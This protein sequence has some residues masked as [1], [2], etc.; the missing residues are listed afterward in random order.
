MNRYIFF[1]ASPGKSDM[2]FAKFL[3]C[4]LIKETEAQ[5]PEIPTGPVNLH[6]LVITELSGG[7]WGWGIR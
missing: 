6:S 1:S 2:G 7:R 3:S 4:V 5:S